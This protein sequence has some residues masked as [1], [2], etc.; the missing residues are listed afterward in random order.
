MAELIPVQYRLRAAQQTL[1]VRWVVWGLMLLAVAGAGSVFAWKWQRT[2]ASK[3]ADLQTEYAERS[4]VIASARELKKQRQELL[5][6]R[7][8]DARLRDDN[9]LLV[10]LNHV[11]SARREF[12]CI[13]QVQIDARKSVK[14]DKDSYFVRITGVTA[15][16]KTYGSLMERLQ[17]EKSPKI[18]VVPE[19]SKREAYLDGDVLRF[20]ILCEKPQG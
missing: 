5:E 11:A 14:G 13:E 16:P 15:D 18:S 7:Q 20:H 17:R 2:Q 3:L 19:S 9:T 1:L 6:R 4:P 10:L 12:D 8:R